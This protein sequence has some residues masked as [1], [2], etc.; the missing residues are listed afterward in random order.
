MGRP[1]DVEIIQP[2][3]DHYSCQSSRK[4]L[5]K[6]IANHKCSDRPILRFEDAGY[7]EPLR[8]VRKDRSGRDLGLK[9]AVPV[10]CI[11]GVVLQQDCE[12]YIPSY[13]FSRCPSIIS[14]HQVCSERLADFA[15]DVYI[16][17]LDHYPSTLLGREVPLQISPLKISDES[18]T[19]GEWYSDQFQKRLPPLH[20]L[21]PGLLGLIGIV[22]GW[23]D[24]RRERH[25]PRSGIV[26]LV[27]CGLWALAC[28]ILLPW[29]T[30]C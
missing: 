9:M 3:I 26:F 20:G 28:F 6:L 19:D 21:I 16:P 13:M 11:K 8:N 17:V 4:A 15:F 7:W 18:V 12:N 29:S 14:N 25:L 5:E 1:I 22:W 30:H 24:I 10:I 27:G 2:P 23:I